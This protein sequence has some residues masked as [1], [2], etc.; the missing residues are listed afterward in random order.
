V[1]ISIPLA[2][3][4]EVGPNWGNLQGY[5][6]TPASL[7]QCLHNARVLAG[8]PTGTLYSDLKGKGLLLGEKNG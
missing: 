8:M 3:D 7:E 5:N 2:V 6:L 1:L 4:F